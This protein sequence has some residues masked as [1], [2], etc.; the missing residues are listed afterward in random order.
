VFLN[1]RIPVG[2]NT[3]TSTGKK[4]GVLSEGILLNLH[5][6]YLELANELRIVFS[7]LVIILD[8]MGFNSA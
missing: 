1:G 2:F 7:Y 5:K 8:F 4:K 6:D 3:L